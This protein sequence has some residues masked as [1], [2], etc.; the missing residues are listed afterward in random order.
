MTDAEYH[1]KMHRTNHSN[2]CGWGWDQYWWECDCAAIPVAEL[3]A[4]QE[5]RVIASK[6]RALDQ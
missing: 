3:R 5:R 2:T 6:R 4:E 1:E